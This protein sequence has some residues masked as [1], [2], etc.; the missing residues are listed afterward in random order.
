MSR[1]K[2]RS[3]QGLSNSS[4]QVPTPA[5]QL[6]SERP[7]AL[8]TDHPLRSASAEPF[9]ASAHKVSKP[10]RDAHHA[11]APSVEPF[12]PTR[13]KYTPSPQSSRARTANSSDVRTMDSVD[14]AGNLAALM[15]CRLKLCVHNGGVKRYFREFNRKKDGRLTS[16]DMAAGFASLELGF[17]PP[18]VRF[19]VDAFDLDGSGGVDYSEFCKTME[20]TDTEMVEQV[21][22]HS[23]KTRPSWMLPQ[24]WHFTPV[25]R[26]KAE[27]IRRAVKDRLQNTFG[28]EPKGMRRAFLFLDNDRAGVLDKRDFKVSM[29]RVGLNLQDEELDMLLAYYDNHRQ[30]GGI[31]YKAFLECFEPEAVGKFNPFKPNE[32]LGVGDQADLEEKHSFPIEKEQVGQ[33]WNNSFGRDHRTKSVLRDFYHNQIQVQ[34]KP[35]DFSDR[36]DVVDFEDWKTGGKIIGRYN[37]NPQSRRGTPSSPT[38]GGTIANALS[39]AR[40]QVIETSP[41]RRRTADSRDVSMRL[42]KDEL[43]HDRSMRFKQRT[44]ELRQSMAAEA[45]AQEARVVEENE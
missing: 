43:V 39:Q 19:L 12:S 14:L 13:Q 42:S 15:R 37:P 44:Q 40:S 22:K 31:S 10:T 8:R 4:S 21:I 41:S 45:A 11:R 24:K 1:R 16:Q 5:P 3:Q 25:Q 9:Y 7:C 17:T 38:R 20:L 35:L 30:E 2:P 29:K 27:T 18:Q 33:Q 6:Q 36:P 34:E 28:G 23:Q 32:P 26:D